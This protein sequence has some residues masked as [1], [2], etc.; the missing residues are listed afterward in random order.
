[1]DIRKVSIGADYKIAMHYIVGQK[2]LGE[3]H[4]IHLIKRDDI[5]NS[6]K[7]YIINKKEEVVLWKEFN[8][9]M[10]ISIEYNIDF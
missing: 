4:E 6:I 1:M 10:P 2:I 5:L 7:I 3:S 9:T 8:F